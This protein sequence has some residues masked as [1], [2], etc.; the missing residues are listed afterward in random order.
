MPYYPCFLESL[1]YQVHD[2]IEAMQAIRMKLNALRVDG[3]A[4]ANNFLMQ[5]QQI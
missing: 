2:V 5:A 4:S 3:G 1:A